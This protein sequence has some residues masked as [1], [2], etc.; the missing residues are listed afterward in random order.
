ME[1]KGDRMR[2]AMKGSVGLN[3]HLALGNIGLC[4]SHR[5]SQ[6]GNQQKPC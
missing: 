3:G 1:E 4:S 6:H 5:L 2:P